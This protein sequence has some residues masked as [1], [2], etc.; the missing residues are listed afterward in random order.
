MEVR[1]VVSTDIE[2]P[3]R[4]VF[5]CFAD[6]KVNARIDKATRSAE[7]LQG[8]AYTKGSVW[9]IRIQGPLGVVVKQTQWMTQVDAPYRQSLRLEQAGMTGEEFETFE[10]EPSGAVHVSWDARYHLSWWMVPL[11][12]MLRRTVRTQAQRWIEDMKR[13]IEA[14]QGPIT[15]IG[16][17]AGHRGHA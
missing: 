3:I 5:M 12:P 11:A 13:A 7:L 14:G 2:K 10:V 15:P 4:D 17:I 8:E 16:E 1:T 9:R 6:P